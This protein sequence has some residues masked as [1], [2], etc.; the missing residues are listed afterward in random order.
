MRVP[1]FA[2]FF[3]TLCFYA[4]SALSADIQKGIAAYSVGNYE[5]AIAEWQ[6]LAENGNAEGQYWLGTLYSNGMGVPQSDAVALKWFGLAADQEHAGAQY[7]IG[8]MH[9]NGWGLDMNVEEAKKWY[10][11]A[12]ENGSPEAQFS[13]GDMYDGGWGM[14]SNYTE[15]FIW[16]SLAAAQEHSEAIHRVKE[17]KGK[18]EAQELAAAEVSLKTWMDKLEEKQAKKD[19]AYAYSTS[20]E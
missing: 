9:A 3:T 12:A 11:R 1:G 16:L 5:E 10:R 8:L 7:N 2:I 15:A 17:L 4:T 6:P 14:E 19:T 18:M 20:E 13:L